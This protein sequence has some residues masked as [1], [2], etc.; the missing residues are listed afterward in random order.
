M[1]EETLPDLVTPNTEMLLCFSD[2]E[3]E[4]HPFGAGVYRYIISWL[5]L[6]DGGWALQRLCFIP[7]IL[8]RICSLFHR[9]RLGRLGCRLGALVAA[10]QRD[11]DDGNR[12]ATIPGT[13]ARVG[14]G[15]G[16]G[17]SAMARPARRGV[18]V[19]R[20]ALLYGPHHRARHDDRP[21]DEQNVLEDAG[22]LFSRIG[23]MTLILARGPPSIALG[24]AHVQGVECDR[25]E[26]GRAGRRSGW[27]VR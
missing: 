18:G 19:Q 26:G 7:P 3:K 25:G 5:C 14:A 21:Q 24:G 11:A 20:A 1:N 8:G 27:H 2:G 17:A 15:I 9:R 6:V 12:V 23:H 10:V 22:H 13:V 16:L 4:T